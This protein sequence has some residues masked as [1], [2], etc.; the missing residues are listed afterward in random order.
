MYIKVL[1]FAKF[2]RLFF[3]AYG[4]SNWL[5]E[6]V[7]GDNWGSWSTKLVVGAGC[8]RWLLLELV[9]GRG[10]KRW[11]LEMVDGVG[12]IEVVLELAVG[13][14]HQRQ[15]PMVVAKCGCHHRW[16]PVVAKDG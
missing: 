6:L 13:V 8:R 15:S 3:L 12:L 14:D 16:L 11:W 7:V 9:A 2:C 4:L 5:V 1:S 10:H